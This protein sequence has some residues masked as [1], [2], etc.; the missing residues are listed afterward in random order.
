M[1]GYILVTGAA[2]FIGSHTCETLLK[3]NYH[4]IGLD[5]FDP[6]YPRW[7]K[8]RN[9]STFKNH[10]NFIFYE[11]DF[12]DSD[13][14]RRVF[15][16]HPITHLVHLGAK[17]G[18]RNS[19]ENPLAY[20]HTN[21]HGTATLL[22]EC[23]LKGIN[24]VVIV[25]SSSVYGG[26]T[27]VPFKETDSI[28]HPMSPYAASK[29]MSE[30]LAFTYHSLYDIQTSVLRFFTVYGPRGR[31]DMAPYIFLHRTL[32]GESIIQ[33]GD[34]SSGRDYTYID[35]IVN[36]IIS[37]MEKTAQWNYEVFNLGNSSP[38]L[39]SEFISTIEEV[40]GKT[41]SR[42]IKPNQPGDSPFT[43]AGIRKAQRMLDYS[44]ET[45][46]KEG[47]TKTLEWYNSLDKVLMV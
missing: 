27:E 34:G 24:K 25:S 30:A 39:L 42:V 45:S 16:R 12:T 8:E 47:L 11:G 19:L 44:P 3:R 20:I 22:E 14:A 33:Y 38:V 43:L 15:D 41:V 4:V 6:Y 23:R 1:T 9:L 10:P 7:V 2:G 28:I 31:P 29:V 18:V 5:N 17:A 36:G 35:D 46:F 40:T 21:A 26:T 13:F 37:A 32:Q